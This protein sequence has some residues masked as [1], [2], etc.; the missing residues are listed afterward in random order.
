M[1][2][3]RLT[4]ALPLLTGGCPASGE[5]LEPPADQFYYPTGM[6]LSPDESTLFVASANADLLY[7]SGTVLPVDVG[8]LD[9]ILDEWLTTGSAPAGRDCDIDLATRHTLVC[10][11]TVAVVPEGAVRIGSFATD[12]RIQ[13]AGEDGMLRLLAAVRGDPSVTWI[14]HDASA[15]RLDCAD[16]DEEFAACDGDHRLTLLRNRED[17]G[18]LPEEPFGLFVDSV[19]GYAV[20]THFSSG[21]ITLVDLP[22][23][24][25][26]PVLADAVAGLFT[27]DP[28]TGELGA[29]AAAGRRPGTATDRIYV[30]SRTDARVQTRLVARPASGEPILVPTDYFFL[31]QV[32]PST[33][34]RGIAFSDDGDRA[35]ILNREPPM[36]HIVDS[37]LGADGMPVNRLEAAVEVCQ[38]AS[39]LTQLDVGRGNRLYVTCFGA[40]QIWVIDPV[41]RSVEAVLDVGLGPH[42][43]VA[44]PSRERLYV[45]NYLEDTV[46]VVDLA[47]GSPTENRVV[48]RLGRQRKSAE[49]SAQ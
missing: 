11:E 24:G 46:A 13:V 3:R 43:L 5:L 33:D 1:L 18:H 9:E 23:G 48:L 35:Y 7:D 31:D 10:D 6:D 14:D 47:A 32:S 37:S 17:V 21:A 42:G 20:V 40:G 45:A 27:S 49:E 4:I 22:A 12:L 26:A 8:Q 30:T 15:G 28:S 25:G 39:N 34:G 44:S 36:L 16:G 29:V 41:A 19:N 2:L 38:Q